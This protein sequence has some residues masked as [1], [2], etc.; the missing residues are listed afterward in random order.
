MMVKYTLGLDFGTNSMRALIAN[1]SDGTELAT[2]VADFSSGEQG[3]LLDPKDANVARQNPADWLESMQRAVKSAVKKAKNADK[4]FS[5]ADIIGIGVDTTGST[6]LPLDEQGIPLAMHD[7]F[8]NNLNAMA[9]LWKDHSSHAEAQEI[10]ETAAKHKPQYLTKCGGTYSS[11]W[12]FSKILHCRRTD[13]KVFKAAYTW[14]ECS[15]YIPAVLTGNTHTD[16]MVRNICAAGHK[17]M[18]SNAWGGLPD[19]KFL[20]RMDAGVAAL[21]RRLYEKA[22]A[23]DNLAGLLSSEWATAMGLVEGTPVA[24]GAMDAHLGAV[25]SG[26]KPGTLVKIIGTSTCDMM[27]APIKQTIRDIPGLCG[28]VPHSILPGYYGLEAGQSA[29]GD[30]FNW[31]VGQLSPDKLGHEQLTE[32]AKALGPGQ[33]GLVALDWNN[34]NRTVLVDPRLSGLLIGQTLQTRPEEVYRALIEATAFGARVIIN[35]F[36][37]YGM[38][39]KEVV[40]CG[41]ISEKNDLL[42]QIYADV[43]GRPMKLA[44]SPQTCALGACM[45]AAAAVGKKN[46]GYD[47]LP[48]AQKAMGGIKTKVFRPIARNKP[49]YDEL[50]KIYLKLHNS[51]GGVRQTDLATIMKRL[52]DLKENA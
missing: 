37:E 3:I 10:T 39:V 47:S 12:F 5:T 23:V 43:L 49:A 6:P 40:N 25:G 26:I 16:K 34:G 35:R 20:A 52:L 2:A 22:V 29:V 15:D 7:K 48:Q 51:F 41:G 18:Y 11:E 24:V 8:K 14:A 30:I 33:S 36:E 50:F 4:D 1:V 9:W 27:V 44:A 19:S 31:F 45:V 17:G 28:I 32:K 46:G 21:R 13:P 38:Q 42:L